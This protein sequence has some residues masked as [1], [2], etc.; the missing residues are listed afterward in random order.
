M[1]RPR[2]VFLFT[3]ISFML[4]ISGCIDFGA[5]RGQFVSKQEVT[6]ND[7]YYK[8]D[9]YP[10]EVYAGD[11]V[12]IRFGISSEKDLEN[13]KVEIVDPCLFS[14]NGNTRSNDN[15]DNIVKDLQ[16][17]HKGMKKTATFELTAGNVELETTCKIKFRITYDSYIKL[18]Q[19]VVVLSDTEYKQREES[20]TLGEIE[21]SSSKEPSSVEAELSFSEPQPFK[22][23]R[24]IQ[25]YIKYVNVGN[26]RIDKI[27]K[28][29]ITIFFPKNLEVSQC[30]GYQKYQ[31]SGNQWKLSK[32]LIF[33]EGET[34]KNSCTAKTK[35]NIPLD[36]GKLV[37]EGK[38]KYV[39]EDTINIKILRR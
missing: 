30:N 22:E 33:Y 36:S 25:I 18:V 13:V 26:G 23:N 8:V 6:T 4:F 20:G 11:T 35:A 24:N 9:V 27:E 10:S 31:K 2:P 32:E 16:N 37:I 38:Y 3:F 1:K 19:D 12:K 15:N 21:I 39:I 29:S 28:D 14:V 17:L 34:E 5:Y 7:L